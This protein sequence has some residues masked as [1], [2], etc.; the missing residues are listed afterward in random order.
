MKPI[1]LVLAVLMALFAL[2]QLDDP[3]GLRW[4][5]LYSAV[6]LAL[7]LAALRPAWLRGAPG[8]VALLALIGLLGVLLV[9]LWPEQRG[10]WRREVWW[11]EETAREGL[12]IAIALLA[13]LVALPAAFGRA[14][15]RTA[16]RAAVEPAPDTDA[17]NPPDAAGSPVDR[18][19]VER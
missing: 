17:E 6:A 2:V 8:R 12:G 13:A 15:T 9:L 5:S 19:V 18:S 1:A 7:A 14:P 16:A 3:D 4:A 10:F 11:E